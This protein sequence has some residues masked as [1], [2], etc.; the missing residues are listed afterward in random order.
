MTLAEKLRRLKAERA[1]SASEIAHGAGVA[2]QTVLDLLEGRTLKP[3]ER[4]VRRLALYFDVPPTH[5]LLP[6][7]ELPGETPLREEIALMGERLERLEEALSKS[8]TGPL[9][10]KR[11]AELENKYFR[12]GRYLVELRGPLTEADR[13]RLLELLD[14]VERLKNGEDTGS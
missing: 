3:H 5:F 14:E 13:E 1:V 6:I 12:G 11:K 9:T 7:D 10:P 8:D 4:T 2:I